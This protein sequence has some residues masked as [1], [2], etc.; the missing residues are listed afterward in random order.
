L[1]HNV[2]FYDGLYI[3]LAERLDVPLL[4]LDNRLAKAASAAAP[5]KVLTA[6]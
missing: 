6:F 5:I 1:R 3:A 4:T 2:S